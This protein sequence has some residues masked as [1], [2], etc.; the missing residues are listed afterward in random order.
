MAK[1]RYRLPVETAKA[2]KKTSGKKRLL[3]P[4]LGRGG[5]GGSAAT[6]TRPVPHGREAMKASVEFTA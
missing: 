1:K 6:F 5:E 4:A 3:T 2:E